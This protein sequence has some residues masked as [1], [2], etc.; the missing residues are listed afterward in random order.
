[1]SLDYINPL[2]NL[3]NEFLIMLENMVIKYKYKADEYETVEMTR[4]A[5]TYLDALQKKDTFFTYRD[6][7]D[8][9]FDAVGLY[10]Y[11][12]RKKAQT[13]I[14]AIPVDNYNEKTGK[15]TQY[16]Q[17]LLERKRNE[18]IENY[19][20]PNNYYRMLNGLPDI[21]TDPRFYYYVDQEYC[22]EYGIDPSIPIH[23]IQDYYNNL[24]PEFP[25]RGD[26][27]MVILEGIG[28]IDRIKNANRT[29]TF[30]VYGGS[31]SGITVTLTPAAREELKTPMITMNLTDDTNPIT[32]YKANKNIYYR[33]T[34]VCSFANMALNINDWIM[35]T[36]TGWKKVDT[37]VNI[38]GE[39]GATATPYLNYLGS[40][41]ISILES[42]KAKNF[43]ILYLDKNLIRSNVYDTFINIYEQC[44]DYMMTVVYQY[45]FKSFMAYYDNFIAMCIMLMAELHLITR[46]IPFEVKRNFFDTYA[47]RMLYEAY[48]M[49]YDIYADIDTQNLIAQNLNMLIINKATNKVI[50]DIA[51]LLGF[52]NMTAYKYY[53]AKK[54]KTDQYGNPVFK[55]TTDF[56]TDT[57]K[58]ETVPDY[59]AMYDIYFQKEEL[60]ENDF[61]QSFNSQV[62][63]VEYN[64][65]TPNDA[66]WWEDQNLVDRKYQ[67]DYNFVETK[68]LSLGLEYNMTEVLFENIILLKTIIHYQKTLEGVSLSIPKIINGA[69]VPLFDVVVLLI[70]LI[71][72]KHNLIGEIISIPTSIISVL[73]YLENKN[74]ETRGLVDTFSFDFDYF[75][76][77]EGQKEINDVEKALGKIVHGLVDSDGNYYVFDDSPYYTYYSGSSVDENG[78]PEII[79]SKVEHDIVERLIKSGALSYQ[80]VDICGND[81]KEFRN[82]IDNVLRLDAE[83]TVRAEKIEALNLVYQNIKGLY[84]FLNVKMIDED[85]K[86][87]YNALRTFY[88]AA[89]YAKEVR[90]V[91]T[92]S[93]DDSN[94]ESHSRTAKSFFEFLYFKNPML[95]SAIFDMNYD[96]EYYKFINNNTFPTYI[97]SDTDN[98]DSL[99]VIDDEDT[100]VGNQIHYSDVVP[101]LPTV[102]IGERVE[103]FSDI[104]DKNKFFDAVK[105][106]KIDISYDI[107]KGISEGEA[108]NNSFISSKIYYYVNHI[109]ARLKLMIEDISYDHMLN[110]VS[111]LLEELLIKMVK[112]IKSFTVDFIGL[113]IVFI[114]DFKQENLLRLIDKVHYID[115]TIVPKESVNFSFWDSIETNLSYTLKDKRKL[116]DIV[117]KPWFTDPDNTGLMPSKRGLFAWFDK[118]SAFSQGTGYYELANTLTSEPSVRLGLSCPLVELVNA[119][120][121][122]ITY[123]SDYT[124]DPGAYPGIMF[125]NNATINSIIPDRYVYTAYII[126][127]SDD[128]GDYTGFPEAGKGPSVRFLS[129]PLVDIYSGLGTTN[130]NIREYIPTE[131][132]IPLKNNF[133]EILTNKDVREWHV[134]GISQTRNTMRVYIDGERCL[135]HTFSNLGSFDDGDSVSLNVKTMPNQNIGKKFKDVKNNY[136]HY[137]C[138]IQLKAYLFADINHNSAELQENTKWLYNQYIGELD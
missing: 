88:L 65:I 92:I 78:D 130:I 80:E 126:C 110:A 111:T 73:D 138:G 19:V 100:I 44:R 125:T 119:D 121:F 50:Y 63:R 101:Y 85:N 46:Q 39:T 133:V 135:D 49:P 62:N 113:D 105:A 128:I 109:I 20:E 2:A 90:D 123:N 38:H 72:R 23:E 118:D 120:Y 58:I 35:G 54:H 64:N 41:R 4:N 77:E 104:G 95:Y 97:H 28:F 83:L 27:L 13:D 33:V 114:C 55:T 45:E 71:C 116:K 21:G 81:V 59:K 102:A 48:N 127:K 53:L 75:R 112:F 136:A 115:K 1:M 132:D 91:F 5:D 68:Y 52:N 22:D 76:T 129:T 93:Y 15:G 14:R 43:S 108:N 98:P 34:T 96:A 56:N 40:H 60:M 30:M 106:G 70:C 26:Q 84:R 124:N 82:Y 131:S 16:R 37:S 42:R 134:I 103:V 6:Y 8:D 61:I 24:D 10:D 31:L 99:L 94:G 9:D 36:D 89:F 12:I 11:D 7:N 32:G 122:D 74:N 57:G 87:R 25:D 79:K 3:Y 66:F 69:T 137:L 86:E 17:K 51:N 107:I 29:N 18:V 117:P 47:I 67:T